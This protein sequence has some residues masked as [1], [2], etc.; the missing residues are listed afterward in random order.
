MEHSNSKIFQGIPRTFKDLICI[1]A[2]SRARDF[3]QNSKIFKDFSR[4]P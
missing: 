4:T 2:L 3:F 1:R